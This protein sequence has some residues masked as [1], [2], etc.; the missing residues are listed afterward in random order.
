MIKKLIIITFLM[1]FIGNIGA[2]AKTY[3][4]VFVPASEKG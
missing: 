2:E 3:K 1:L 4:M